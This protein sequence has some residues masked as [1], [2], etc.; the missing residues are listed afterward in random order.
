MLVEYNV[1]IIAHDNVLF[2]PYKRCWLL[3]PK[4][5]SVIKRRKKWRRS[6]HRL[7]TPKPLM[8]CSPLP[9]PSSIKKRYTDSTV[10][11]AESWYFL[12]IYTWRIIQ[13][14]FVSPL[15]LCLKATNSYPK[16][17][18]GCKQFCY[19][20]WEKSYV[21]MYSFFHKAQLAKVW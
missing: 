13:M 2:I 3:Q 5:Q 20:I 6:R 10:F 18:E 19:C 15:D 12:T 4:R 14:R 9:T 8:R 11:Y 21:I 7:K 16:V 17:A 1:S